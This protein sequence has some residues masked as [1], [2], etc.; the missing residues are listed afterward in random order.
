MFLSRFE[1][2]NASVAALL[3]LCL[4][5]HQLLLEITGGHCR[6]FCGVEREKVT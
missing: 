1:L 2:E 3:Q 4:F 5:P 6:V